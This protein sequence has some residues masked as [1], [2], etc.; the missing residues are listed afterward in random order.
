MIARGF[1][2]T[3]EMLRHKIDLKEYFLSRCWKQIEGNHHYIMASHRDS[4]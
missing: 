2:L 4:A 3:L 1:A